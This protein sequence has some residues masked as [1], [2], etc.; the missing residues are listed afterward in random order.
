PPA[1]AMDIHLRQA[2]DVL[3]GS[4]VVTCPTEGVYGLSC[5]PDDPLALIELLTIKR[6]DPAKGLILI[7]ADAGQLEDWIGPGASALPEP[8]PE[9][10]VTW[11]VPALDRVSPL[12]RGDH[13]KLAVRLTTNPVARALCREV[14]SPLVSTSANIAGQPVARNRYVLRRQFHDRV[15]YLV[16]GDCGPARGASEIRDLE[17]GTILRKGVA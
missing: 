12:V 16:P 13:E 11:L 4:G 8:D 3:L 17:T 5:M 2:A 14:D 15:D 9:R 6:R 1:G 10:P 7:A